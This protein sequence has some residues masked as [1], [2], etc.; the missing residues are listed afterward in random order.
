MT[1]DLVSHEAPYSQWWHI[2]VHVLAKIKTMIHIAQGGKEELDM[3]VVFQGIRELSGKQGGKE[4]L[5]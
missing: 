3:Y 1:F 4:G 2:H 5:I